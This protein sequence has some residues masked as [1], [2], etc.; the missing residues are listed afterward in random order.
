MVRIVYLITAHKY[1]NQVSR[2]IDRIRTAEDACA[3]SAFNVRTKADRET[4]AAVALKHAGFVQRLRT[5]SHD[6]WGSFDQV[7]ENLDGM[8]WAG[9][10]SFDYFVNLSAQCYPLW[11]PEHVKRVLE[12]IG[13]SH[14]ELRTYE[15]DSDG[16]FLAS[17]RRP[18]RD[19]SHWHGSPMNVHRFTD[20]WYQPFTIGGRRVMLRVPNIKR[21][22]PL[23]LRPCHGS[24]WFCLRREHVEAILDFVKLHPR[25]LEAFRHNG[26]PI[27]NFFNT[28]IWYLVDHGEIS[29]GNLRYESWD[30]GQIHILPFLASDIPALLSS[31]A[32]WA[33]KFDPLV[34]PMPLAAIDRSRFGIG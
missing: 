9:A 16:N 24:G 1:P 6:I 34:D 2:L 18:L 8:A 13:K 29:A 14:I 4:W 31:S 12:E 20:W 28:L 33:R 19:A 32:L 5:S 15:A 25:V 23:G 7:T 30:E 17:L 10:Q 22:L 21:R 27:E 3:L 26:I 11:P